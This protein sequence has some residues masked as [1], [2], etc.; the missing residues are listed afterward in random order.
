MNKSLRD[1]CL[2]EMSVHHYWLTIT[3]NVKFDCYGQQVPFLCNFDMMPSLHDWPRCMYIA[4]SRNRTL[5]REHGISVAMR[6]KVRF[7]LTVFC[8]YRIL[9][10]ARLGL[11][12]SKPKRFASSSKRGKFM[13]AKVFCCW[14]QNKTIDWKQVHTRYGYANL[15]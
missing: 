8:P 13:S 15:T 4:S 3:K 1:Y 6:R 7:K 10:R 12:L 2:Y 9:A 14:L 11:S 5:Y